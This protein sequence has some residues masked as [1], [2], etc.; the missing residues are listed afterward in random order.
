[1]GIYRKNILKI[2]SGDMVFVLNDIEEWYIKTVSIY[3]LFSLLSTEGITFLWFIFYGCL[4]V[5][6]TQ[7]MVEW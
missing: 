1:M 2:W 3:S 6:H 4:D 7:I 5:G